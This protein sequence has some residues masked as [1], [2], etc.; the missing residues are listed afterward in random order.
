MKDSEI[1]IEQDVDDDFIDLIT[2]RK[3]EIAKEN[4][5]L[6]TQFRKQITPINRKTTILDITRKMRKNILILVMNKRNLKNKG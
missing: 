5:R 6:E 4:K 1:L 3:T 2:K